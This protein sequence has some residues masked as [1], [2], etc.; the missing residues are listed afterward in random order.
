MVKSDYIIYDYTEDRYVQCWIGRHLIW[1]S[2][3]K[4]AMRYQ[5]FWYAWV[6]SKLISP[7]GKLKVIEVR[8]DIYGV[9]K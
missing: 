4:Y 1:C 5:W 3:Y 9:F 8:R 6:R 7:S 2:S